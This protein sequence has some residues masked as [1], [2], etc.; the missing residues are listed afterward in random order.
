MGDKFKTKLKSTLEAINEAFGGDVTFFPPVDINFLENFER[1]ISWKFPEIFRY[2]YTQE[3][4]GLIIN[5]KRIFSFYL[6]DNKKTW[7]ENLE[8]MNDS[9][10]SPWFKGRPHIFN[11]YVVIGQDNTIIFCLSKKYNFDNPAIYICKNPNDMKGVDLDR[12]DLDL[13]GLITQMIKKAF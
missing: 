11:D 12:L 8:R 4:N 9:K 13:E 7:V 2:F 10:I 1:K 5:D 6:K 3:S